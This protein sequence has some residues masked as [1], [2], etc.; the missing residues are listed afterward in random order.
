L[1]QQAPGRVL[2]TF[3]EE[4]DPSLSVIHVLDQSGRAVEA[5]KAERVPGRPL[6]LTVPLKQLPNGVYTVS[7]RVV[8]R[9]DGHVTAGAVSF[10]VGVSPAGARPL[11]GSASAGSPSPSVLAVAGRWAF[12][13][14]LA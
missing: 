3:T 6:E 4:P 7:W 13:W 5:G 14:G 10:G 1:L 12:Y 11:A 9:V 8:S 2:I